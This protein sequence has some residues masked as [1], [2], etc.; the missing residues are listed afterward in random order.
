[1]TTTTIFSRPNQSETT[2]GEVKVGIV[3]RLETIVDGLVE[4]PG[5]VKGD[6]GKWVL[7]EWL[8][9]KIHQISRSG[10]TERR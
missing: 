4:Y 1:M 6:F 2:H 3:K 7:S 10:G 8:E 5:S 9:A